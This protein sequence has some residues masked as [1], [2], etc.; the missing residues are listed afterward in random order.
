M[1]SVTSFV[2]QRPDRSKLRLVEKLSHSRPHT[3]LAQFGEPECVDARILIGV[4]DLAASL[5]DAHVEIDR[6]TGICWPAV[7]SDSN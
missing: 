5:P 4:F 3:G 2:G 1:V 7:Q 6:A